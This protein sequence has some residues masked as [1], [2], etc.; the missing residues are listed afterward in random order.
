MRFRY[1]TFGYGSAHD[2]RVYRCSS[3]R[4]YVENLSHYHVIADNAYSSFL[5]IKTPIRVENSEND[6]IFN[7][8]HRLHRVTVEN[9][10]GFLKG[11]FKRFSVSIVNGEEEKI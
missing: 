9:A 2:S 3:L 8:N 11:K 5:N 6:R 10:F 1:V 7:R 4:R